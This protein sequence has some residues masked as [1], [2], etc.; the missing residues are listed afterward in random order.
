MCTRKRHILN[1]FILAIVDFCLVGV[2]LNWTVV[3]RNSI[4]YYM[5][6]E[7]LST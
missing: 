1:K 6:T 2:K 5:Y 4:K 3:L 7:V